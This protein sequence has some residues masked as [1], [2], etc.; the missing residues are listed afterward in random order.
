MAQRLT[1]VFHDPQARRWRR[2]KLTAQIA[3]VAAVV[4]FGILIATVATTPVLPQSIA[5]LPKVLSRFR[6]IDRP[7]PMPEEGV[8]PTFHLYAEDQRP[9]AVGPRASPAGPGELIGFYVNWDRSSFTSLQ[10]NL[11][12]L[13]KLMPE[14]LHAIAADGTITIDSQEK[15]TEVLTFIHQRRPGL[16]IVPIVDN[17][18]PTTDK[19][20]GAALSKMLADPEVRSR[21]IA[22]TLSAVKEIAGAGVC[23]HFEDISPGD[24]NL[25]AFQRELYARFHPLG[26]EVVQE[27]PLDDAAVDYR[28]LGESNDH[29]ILNAY[30]EHASDDAPS[31][32]ASQS[33]YAHGLRRRFADLPPDRYIIAIGNYGYDWKAGAKPAT[34]LSFQESMNAARASGGHDLFEPHTLN[35]TFAYSDDTGALHRV[36]FLDAVTAFNQLVE[37]QR[38]GPHG[39]ALWRLGSEDPSIWPV[40]N[41]RARLDHSAVEAVSVLAPGYDLEYEGQGEVV[42]VTTGPRAGGRTAEYSPQSGLIVSEQITAYPLSY[43]ITRWGGDRPKKIALTFDDGPD[44]RY[45]AMVLDVLRRYHA[46]A[47]F[48][49]I[50]TN[51]SVNPDL[52]R[53]IVAEGHEIG[54]HTFT[55]PNIATISEDQLGIEINATERLLESTLGR[56]SILFRPPYAID[57]DPDTPDDVRP[58]LFTSR[59]GYY[60]VEMHIDPTDWRTPGVDR[61][62]DAVLEKATNR[63]GSV[64]LLHDGGGDRLQTVAALP[65]II[66]G[67]RAQ[68]FELVTVSGLLGLSRDA[69]M[70][71]ISMASTTIAHI[72]H[73][74]FSLIQLLAT[75]IRDLFVIGL[76]LGIPRPLFVGA[77]AIIQWRTKRRRTAPPSGDLPSVSAVVPA[78]NEA[79]V[80]CQTIHAVLRST[81][82]NLDVIVVDDGS[83]DDT[84]QRVVETF[85]HDPRVRAF[86]RPNGGKGQALNYGIG[87]TQA[88]I[89]ITL[90]ADTIIRADAIDQLVHHF[91][92]PRV[93]AVAGNAKV[94]NRR[95]LLARWQALEYITTQ[96]LERR[97]FDILNCI[98]VVPGAIGAWRRDVILQAGGFVGETIA[99]DADLT[100]AI[101]RMGHKIEYEEG[102]IGLTEAPERVR[103]LLKQRF[104]WM[105]GTLQTVWKH[106]DTLFRSRYGSLGIVAVP[107]VLLFQIAFSLVA[108][109]VD[110]FIVL[111]LAILVWQRSQHPLTYSN[112]GLVRMFAYFALFQGAEFLT[113]VLAFTLERGEDRRL[114]VWVLFQRFFY[115]QLMYYVGIKVVVTAVRGK[116]VGWSK[117]ERRATVEVKV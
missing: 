20:E 41:R 39:Y 117:F 74:G 38:Y 91:T 95:S 54:N 99:E 72:N 62:V 51:A 18:N 11:S 109:L 102:A 110:F 33:W 108:P 52:L 106:L 63:A 103:S 111:T 70:P 13:D 93:G 68:G 3:S 1:Q 36:W 29:L 50:G 58:L 77:L 94:G 47:T 64:V 81:Y 61:I 15:Q 86:S 57:T 59:L 96:N 116:I 65:R 28:A 100:F 27:V 48:F 73:V 101:L 35:P 12:H 46:P 43:V 105:Y 42:K 80:I 31:P 34:E 89:I 82:P 45:T 60:M 113:S 23:I 30:D 14:W 112:A 4:I 56:R 98:T 84:Y 24:P 37:G 40:F 78:F 55:H 104:R 90:D 114:L 79:K 71:P 53:R 49:V 10:R 92:D 6:P 69:V 25:R 66:A 9:P 75:G 85:A 83:T 97:A 21:A 7:R 26:L 16:P 88:E 107:Y 44:P 87:Q 5:P 32:I 17:F 67:L 2:F 22:N 8:L 76:V 115:R 19:W